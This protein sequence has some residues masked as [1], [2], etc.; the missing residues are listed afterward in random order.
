MTAQT[1]QCLGTPG[2]RAPELVLNAI[3]NTK[4]DIWS[5]GCILF[6]LSVGHKPF[7]D[8]FGV[9]Y[10]SR[11]SK[12]LDIDLDEGFG[13]GCRKD[14]TRNVLNMLQIEPTLR[15]TSSSLFDEF[16][17]LLDGETNLMLFLLIEPHMTWHNKT[18]PV[19]VIPKEIPI[20]T[21]STYE[22]AVLE[23]P[24]SYW[25][26]RSLCQKLVSEKSLQT[27]IERCERGVKDFVTSPSPLMMLSNLH[28]MNDDYQKAILSSMEAFV[29]SP[30]ILSLALESEDHLLST[31][32]RDVTSIEGYYPLF[33]SI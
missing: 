17:N 7:H 12:S 29:F 27:A 10:Y 21:I 32:S 19:S 18:K 22:A 16:S 14:I 15:P 2:Y 31:G 28:A 5:M 13:E 6:E 24:M 33:H 20:D 11:D 1:T 8:D 25:L 26:W 9:V 4:V 3:F 30:A 23:E